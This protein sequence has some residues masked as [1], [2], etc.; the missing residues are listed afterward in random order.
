MIIVV[1]SSS[2]SGRAK[3]AEKRRTGKRVDGQV[4]ATKGK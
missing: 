4:D 1:S 2:S 3:V